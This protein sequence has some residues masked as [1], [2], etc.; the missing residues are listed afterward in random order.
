MSALAGTAVAVLAG[1]KAGGGE[2]GVGVGVGS[3]DR[4]TVIV[5]VGAGGVGVAGAPTVPRRSASALPTTRAS[6]T[7]ATPAESISGSGARRC[8]RAWIT[9]NGRASCRERV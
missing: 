8:S 1:R 6:R 2:Y 5:L 4:T 7:T 9:E 3:G